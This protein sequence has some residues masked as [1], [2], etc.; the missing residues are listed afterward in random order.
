MK[1]TLQ[2]LF[3]RHLPAPGIIACGVRLPD[4]THLCQSCTDEISH[5]QVELALNRLALAADSLNHH[6]LEANT[7]CWTFDRMRVHLAQRPDGSTLIVMAENGK[8][9]Q[10]ATSTDRL[11]ADFND[12]PAI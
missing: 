12:L 7:F 3:E 4:R 8:H 10:A 2:D 11:L 9:A 1:S 5:S 6:R